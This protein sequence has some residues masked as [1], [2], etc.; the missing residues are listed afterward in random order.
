MPFCPQCDS[1]EAVTLGTLGGAEWVRCRCCGWTYIRR[2][3]GADIEARLNAAE[4]S[5]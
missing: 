2:V 5:A 3:D 4:A 1:T